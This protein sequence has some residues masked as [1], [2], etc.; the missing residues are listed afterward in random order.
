MWTAS[1]TIQKVWLLIQ[2]PVC[3]RIPRAGSLVE[4][5][6]GAEGNVA[7]VPEVPGC[8]RRVQRNGIYEIPNAKPIII[9]A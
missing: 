8:R 1:N 6:A 9:R 7:V 3:L 2:A 4:R 5:F